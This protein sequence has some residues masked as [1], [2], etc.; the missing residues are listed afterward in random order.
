MKWPLR[1]IFLRIFRKFFEN[2]KWNFSYFY[3]YIW[4]QDRR[5]NY[6]QRDGT[7]VWGSKKRTKI[8]SEDAFV[9]QG[10]GLKQPHK[11]CPAYAQD[12][13]CFDCMYYGRNTVFGTR[14]ISYLPYN[15][16]LG[17]AFYINC[18]SGHLKLVMFWHSLHSR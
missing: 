6:I 13:L 9:I 8:F 5:V 14:K 15:N 11:N 16:Y 7:A 12:V 17:S 2:L 3:F 4:K 18:D 10:I 1:T